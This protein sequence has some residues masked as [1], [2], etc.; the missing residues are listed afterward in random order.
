MQDLGCIFEPKS[1]AVAGVSPGSAGERY[2]DYLLQYGFK[3]G[4]YPLR[5]K[6]GEF[7]GVKIYPGIKTYRRR[8]T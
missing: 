8:W 7:R 3:G 6:G 5:P 1:V 4:I 2:T